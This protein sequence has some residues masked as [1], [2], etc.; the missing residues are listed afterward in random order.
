MLR[1]FIVTILAALS[2][3]FVG[4]RSKA[5]APTV[6]A[7]ASGAE[8]GSIKG[9]IKTAVKLKLKGP[10]S[11]KHVVVYVDE[12]KEIPAKAGAASAV[13]KQE[14]LNFDPH[15]VA[16]SKGTTIEFTNA[17]TV[18]HNV[19][20][21]E[22]CCKIDKDTK[23]GESLKQVFDKVGVVPVVCRLHPEMSLFVVVTPN[24]KFAVVEIK[25][26]KAEDGDAAVEVDFEIAD[27]P[28]GEYTLKTWHKKLKETTVKVKVEAG[29]VATVEITLEK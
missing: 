17:D 5:E 11:Q 2:T 18:V 7:T 16:V 10:V 3:T 13:V 14:K 15:V 25:K 23:Q 22:E 24:P 19:F 9:K 8:S 29:K 27:V 1:T 12:C 6:H 28:P 21:Q 26:D 4:D 20:S